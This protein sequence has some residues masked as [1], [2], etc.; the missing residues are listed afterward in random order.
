[1]AGF[2]NAFG[3]NTGYSGRGPSSVVGTT[4]T[5]EGFELQKPFLEDLFG[6]AGEFYFDTTKDDAGVE[7]KTLR[8]PEQ[9]TGETI[10]GFDP[11]QE[12][13]FGFLE[14]IG[15][16]GLA[17]TGQAGS[18]QYMT[19]AT[20]LADLAA[21]K[22]DAAT[23]KEYINPYL[24]NVTRQA[25]DEV[26]RR[27]QSEIEPRLGAE[28]AAAGAF[29]GSRAAIMESEGQRNLLRQ[30]GDIRERGLAA[31]FDQGRRAFEAQ[32]AREQGLAGFYGQLAET[33]PR[34]GAMEAG[35]ISSVGEQRRGLEQ[36]R[37]DRAEKEF[38]EAR[39]APIRQLAGYQSILQGF[40]YSPSTYE[41][42]STYNPQPS[43]GQQLIGGLGTAGSLYGAFGGFNPAGRRKSG[44]LVRRRSGGQ[45]QGGLAGLERHQNNIVNPLY[46]SSRPRPQYGWKAPR[47]APLGG[48]MEPGLVSQIGR[49]L[50]SMGASGT[51]PRYQTRLGPERLE[52]LDEMTTDSAGDEQF[53]EELFTTGKATPPKTPKTPEQIVMEM[54]RK[55]V[56][57]QNVRRAPR[58]PVPGEFPDN[59]ELATI[60]N[61]LAKM[62]RR[63]GNRNISRGV[64]PSKEQARQQ[65]TGEKARKVIETIS[66]R[67]SS[68]SIPLLHRIG[69]AEAKAIE[70]FPNKLVGDVKKAVNNVTGVR[71][72]D[73]GNY[74]STLAGEMDKG[75]SAFEAELDA[76]I[77]N[78][79]KLRTPSGDKT[80]QGTY[81][82][83]DGRK[84]VGEMKGGKP[85][86][87]GTVE[88]RGDG[89]YKY[90]GG[91]RD[92]KWHGQ[93]TL[94]YANGSKYIGEYKDGEA[95]GEGTTIFSNGDKYIGTKYVGNIRGGKAVDDGDKNTVSN[96]GEGS[97]T[98]SGE[99]NNKAVVEVI[100]EVNNNPASVA[101]PT[102][103]SR[104][105]TKV[106]PK[107]DKKDRLD[108]SR[109]FDD[110]IDEYIKI[111]Q[112]KDPDELVTKAENA[113]RQDLWL[114]AAKFFS[115]MGSTAP[116]SMGG[117]GVSN[118]LEGA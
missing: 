25:E 53:L 32:K 51:V 59:R 75:Y 3:G 31:G 62:Q 72:D 88:D 40:P 56:P 68:P 84:Y 10:A 27:Y 99:V 89:Q 76:S 114:T 9:Y 81:T 46:D 105:S 110:A 113:R 28:A 97:S 86:G 38:I 49:I 118:I 83:P 26:L 66:K 67:S 35:L 55:R 91:F 48:D 54:A 17:A 78:V 23:A 18:G 41:V 65:A 44:G 22:F 107:K 92:G 12:K 50:S 87:W 42:K 58:L 61:E 74:V 29:G 103:S 93:G 16:G 64:L 60:Q 109:K 4:L 77:Q 24:Q 52:F 6:A 106:E 7:T 69:H 21:G 111:L 19:Q 57:T 15:A 36:A 45:I 47:T 79:N 108:Y 100:T 90:V 8:V 13:A 104:K 39:D 82:Y 30:M 101:E 37:L 85:H 63:E 11:T 95:H 2:I 33:A 70:N 80:K 115:K 20:N 96:Q 94:T 34:I 73:L 112:A 98:A 71:L 5:N 102:F 14:D 43:F 116:S 117:S 1:M